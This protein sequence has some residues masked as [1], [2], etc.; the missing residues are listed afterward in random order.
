MISSTIYDIRLLSI[1]RASKL[2]GIRYETV[3]KLVNLG[4][5]KAVSTINNR[6]K[7]PY[8]SLVDFVSRE[9]IQFKKQSII[10]IEE[11]QN[12]I[13]SLIKEYSN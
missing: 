11:T 2:L 5:I 10:P 7:I 12:K 4:K 3:K 1:N 8:Q 13:D 9:N 6:F